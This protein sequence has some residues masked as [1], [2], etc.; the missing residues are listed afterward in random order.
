MEQVRENKLL[1]IRDVIN[2]EESRINYLKGLIRIAE[3][4]KNK[5]SVEEGYIYKIAEIIGASYS[6]IWQAE[7]QQNNNDPIGINFATKQEKSLFL[8][9]AL[10][11]CWLDD[12]YSDAER[13]EIIKIGNDFGIDLAEI[14]TIESWIKQGIEWMSA[15]AE[16][17]GLER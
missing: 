5:T 17:I 12:E 15:G 2:T 9:Q 7:E 1:A 16:L 3:S 8:M 14:K 10:Y 11:M 6:E 4:D 13:K